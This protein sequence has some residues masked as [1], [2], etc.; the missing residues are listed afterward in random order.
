MER[1]RIG[2]NVVVV[3]GNHK[4]KSGRIS[5]VL[6]E[7]DAVVIEGVNVVKRHMRATPQRAGG[8]LEI[9]APLPR[10]KVMLLDPESGKPT[11][12]KFQTKD[13]A[14]QRVA[15]SGAVIGIQAAPV[16]EPEGEAAEG[17]ENS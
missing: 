14:K 16:A 6:S 1:L 9:E 2:D 4:G 12:V 5:R 3:R 17:K 7:K 13:G 10:S 8:I 15:K 11:R